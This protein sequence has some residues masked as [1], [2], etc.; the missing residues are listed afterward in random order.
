[1]TDLPARKIDKLAVLAL[2]VAAVGGIPGACQIRVYLQRTS[3]KI[4]FNQQNSFA[5]RIESKDALLNDKLGILL[6]MITI[7]GK[8]SQPT[9]VRDMGLSLMVGDV[10]M[11]GTRFGLPK[12]E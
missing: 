3:I 7:A 4:N 9:F 8:G 10:W 6:Y 2:V 11:K 5:C 12:K 1:M